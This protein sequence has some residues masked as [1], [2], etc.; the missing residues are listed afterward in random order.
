MNTSVSF[1]IKTS[2]VNSK[3]LAP[4]YARLTVDGVRKEFSIG[5]KIE[6]SK[7]I[8]KLGVAKGTNEVA[9]SINAL[10][11]TIRLKFNEHCRTLLETNETVTTDLLLNKYF[12]K[13]EK[14]R[15]LLELMEY[16]NERIKNLI[17]KDYSKATYVKYC[18]TKKHLSNFITWKFN[19]VDVSLKDLKYSFI[20]DFEFYLKTVCCCGQNSTMKHIKNLKKI[21]NI[22]VDNQWLSKSPFS[23]F[24][25]KLEKVDREYLTEDELNNLMQKEFRI[26]RLAQVRDAF[27]FACFTG[28]AFKDLQNLTQKNIVCGIDG[29]KYLIYSRIKT[30][31]SARIPILPLAQA[32]IEKYQD[33]SLCVTNNKLLP[34]PS[35]Q[36]M[37][38]YLKEI[39]DTCGI[40]KTLTT[41]M[42]RHT[43]ATTVTLS[44]NVPL[45][46]V[47]KMLGHT[48]VKTT[49][50]YA[51]I[52]DK[53]IERDMSLLFDKYKVDSCEKEHRPQG[54]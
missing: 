22:A 16:H 23:A 38:A 3:G 52:I 9:K 41:H 10:L 33:S 49:Q 42:A 46:T 25:I 8:S 44:N 6:P 32:I 48:D 26:P 7:W 15:A 39:A 4:I 37:N 1:T 35:N 40:S 11:G 50:I 19:R 28:A 14:N 20:T 43:F 31:I 53:K 30:K 18:T 36:K 13:Q 24:R 12:G 34:M 17:G 21:I 54:E 2:K 27:V 5:R 51:R 29:K 47:S 45:E